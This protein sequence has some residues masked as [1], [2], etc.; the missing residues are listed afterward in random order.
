MKQS[1]IGKPAISSTL[2]EEALTALQKAME[3]VI[4]LTP[5]G[6]ILHPISPPPPLPRHYFEDERQ[7]ALAALN[8]PVRWDAETEIDGDASYVRPG[9]SRKLLGDLRQGAWSIQ[10]ELD[11]HGLRRLDAK[12]ELVSFLHECRHHGVRC[13]RI[14]H[15][16]GLGSVNREPVLRQHVRYWLRQRDEI[17]AYVEARPRDGGSGAMIVLMKS[18]GR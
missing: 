12:Q 4:P 6:R 10:A 3:G 11:L 8:D 2:D 17:L 9:L 1:G 18:K 14:M 16:K 5:H 15:G 7:A 13:V